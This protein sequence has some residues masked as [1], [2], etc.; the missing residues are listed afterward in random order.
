MEPDQQKGPTIR[1]SVVALEEA[2]L[3]KDRE[4][5]DLKAH[6]AE[7]EAARDTAPATR[8]KQRG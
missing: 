8:N 5:A 1:D 6:I 2:G 3:A 7:L 4:I